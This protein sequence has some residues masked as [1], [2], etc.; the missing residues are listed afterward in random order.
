LHIGTLRPKLQQ[1]VRETYQNYQNG[2]LCL[3]AKRPCTFGSIHYFWQIEL[4]PTYLA[5]CEGFLKRL[6]QI[7]HTR[8]LSTPKKGRILRFMPTGVLKHECITA[9]RPP[10]RT[11]TN[12]FFMM[13]RTKQSSTQ[14][15]FGPHSVSCE[16]WAP[17][18]IKQRVGSLVTVYTKFPSKR[19]T[20]IRHT[21]PIN[22]TP[23]SSVSLS[24]LVYNI[25]DLNSS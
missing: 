6:L 13:N 21:R 11:P 12:F 19:A 25:H 1:V 7:P 16:E 9:L 20:N 8:V 5:I 17:A 2:P 3:S 18:V 14:V 23:P 22:R 4:L 10:E 24:S 15:L